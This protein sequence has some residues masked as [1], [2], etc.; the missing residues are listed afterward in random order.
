[1]TVHTVQ[2]DAVAEW[3]DETLRSFWKLESLGVEPFKD[4]T[5]S[6]PSH[7]IEMKDWQYEV[8]LPW[9]HKLLTTN[10]E[11]SLERLLHKLWH[12]PH[13]L[14]EYSAIIHEQLNMG[15]IEHIVQTDT[16]NRTHY[17]PHHAIVW[18]DKDTTKVRIVYNASAHAKGPSLNDW[19]GPN[20]TRRYLEILLRFRSYSVAWNANIEKVFLMISISPQ[21]RD[22]LCFLWVDFKHQSWCCYISIHM[23]SIWGNFK[24]LPSKFYDSASPQAI[25]LLTPRT[26]FQAF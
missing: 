9:F 11:L 10:Y 22:V 16:P 23:C 5:I 12:D 19:Q 18:R 7:T 17:L 3:L 15:I 25:F 1:M 20:S 26:C 4:V 24:S 14:E 8:S 21:D 6:N 2:V 13:T